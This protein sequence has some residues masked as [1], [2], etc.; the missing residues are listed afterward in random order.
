[1]FDVLPE[2][3]VSKCKQLVGD[4]RQVKVTFEIVTVH[5]PEPIDISDITTGEMSRKTESVLIRRQP[6]REQQTVQNNDFHL[7]VLESSP[8]ITARIAKYS[9]GTRRIPRYTTKVIDHGIQPSTNSRVRLYRGR[10]G[11]NSRFALDPSM[12]S[13]PT[14][15]QWPHQEDGSANSLI[16]AWW[17]DGQ[18][19]DASAGK[20]AG[21]HTQGARNA[22]VSDLI[23]LSI[24]SNHSVSQPSVM[25]SRIAVVSGRCLDI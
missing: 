2:R 12:N 8:M 18:A 23:S 4:D 17:A 21:R 19:A 1:M 6:R 5:K 9:L 24:A 20:H 11:P 14:R 10:T 3:R 13:N 25:H 15:G 22:R 16:S 7:V